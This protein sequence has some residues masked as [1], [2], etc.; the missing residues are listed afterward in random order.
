MK[1]ELFKDTKG[2]IYTLED[3]ISSLK[4]LGA[5]KAEVLY[6]HTD[7][8][9][10]KPLLK[11]K[12]F[13]AKLYEA[14]VSLGVKTLIFPT[15]TFSFCNNEAYD[16]D[17]SKCTMGM[18]N[19]YAR[20]RENSFRTLDPLLSV[21]VI[22]D[23][24]EDFHNLSKSSCGKGSSFEILS[25]SDKNMILFFG[26]KPTQ[27]FTFLH[28]VE[29]IYNV[30]YRYPK[31]F[32]G[33]VI[34]GDKETQETYSLFTLY[35]TVTPSVDITF[36]N[37]L[38]DKGILTRVTLGEKEI[39]LVKGKSVHNEMCEYFDRDINILLARPYDTFELGKSYPYTNVDS[40]R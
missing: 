4:K 6:I 1:T 24:P 30:P 21:C 27:C 14:I 11:R 36:Q 12:E 31:E 18:L 23:V 32:T 22:G 9:F 15:Y 2:V 33:T 16:V 3:V 5:D 37:H 29:E 28:Y 26:A 39:M 7:I 17:N 10:G 25:K 35:D 38:E 13:V 40:I 19:E 8:G 34:D 20:K